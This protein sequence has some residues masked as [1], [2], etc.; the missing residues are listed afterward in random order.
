M[1]ALT[2]APVV[3]DETVGTRRPR[4]RR[5]SLAWLGAVPFLAYAFL[6]LVLPGVSVIVSAFQNTNGSF[7]TQWVR[8]LFQGQFLSANVNSLELAALSAITGGVVGF[9]AAYA[10]VTLGRPRWLRSFVTTFSAVAANFAGV[11]LAFA[12]VATIG[13]EGAMTKLLENALGVNISSF[14]LVSVTGL[15]VVY[16]YFQI[17]LM[18]L[19]VAPA[20]DGLRREW[21]EAAANLGA[22]A[23]QYWLRVGLPVLAPSVIGAMLLLFASGFAAYATAVALTSGLVNLVATLIGNYL[24][25]NVIAQPQ[26]GQAL[27]LDMLVVLFV[28]VGLYLLLQRRASKWVR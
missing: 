22:S 19:V 6:F 5:R 27:G 17:P 25:G 13:S 12:F 28:A 11:P 15:V 21:R 23:T 24:S 3:V 14:N 16:T 18:V 1:T 10:V 20:L 7:T 26:M 8:D 4:P 2:D 9:L